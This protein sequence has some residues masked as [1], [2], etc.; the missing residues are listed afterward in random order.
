MV[1]R[2]FVLRNTR[3]SEVIAQEDLAV[4]MRVCPERP[5]ARGDTVVRAGDPALEMHVIAR[6]QVNVV[7]PTPHGDER[8]LAI[9]GPD[10]FIGEAF[11]A[12]GSR[13]R[14]EAVALTDLVTCPVSRQRYL[15]MALHAPGF[16]LVFTE[17]L[18]GHLFD[19]RQQPANGYEA[20]L[21]RVG[22]VLLDQVGRFG[23]EGADGWSV[24]ETNLMHDDIAAMVS[25][26][27]V[28]VS[29]AMSEL[30]EQGLVVGSR[31]DYR[32]HVPALAAMVQ[33][34]SD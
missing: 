3:F 33:A 28:S 6:G 20:V 7:V 19:C 24:L 21:V 5:Y 15:Q 13:Y 23:H 32:V 26:T 22:K 25:A 14:A 2:P 17:V 30:R 27:R 11:V 34:P 29:T 1:D 8:I 31:G 9:C 16:V 12:E 10:D 4:F 18:A